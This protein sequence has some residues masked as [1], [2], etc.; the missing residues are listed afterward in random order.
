MS[1]QWLLHN[2]GIYSLQ[3]AIFAATGNLLAWLFRIHTPKVLLAWRQGLLAACLLLPLLQPWSAAPDTPS[4]ISIETVT[5]ARLA[6]AA[7]PHWVWSEI[8]I[9][10]VA[11]GVVVRLAWLTLG[12][13][14]LRRLRMEAQPFTMGARRTSILLSAD[15]ASPVTF[16]L[17]RPV[18]LL[19]AD[20]PALPASFRRAI[21][22]HEFA[23][24]RRLDWGCTMAEELLRAVFWFHPAIHWMLAGIQLVREQAVDAGVIAATGSRDA[25]LR[26]LLSVAGTGLQPDLV[27]APLFLRGS[28]LAARVALIVKEPFM[29]TKRLASSLATMACVLAVAA[30]FLIIQFPLV[31]PAQPIVARSG[32]KLIHRAPVEYPSSAIERGIAGTVIVEATLN[33]NG[34][35]EDAKVVSGPEALRRAALKSVLEWHYEDQRNGTVQVAIDF[36]LPN[37]TGAAAPPNKLRRLEFAGIPQPVQETVIARAGLHEGQTIQPE[38]EKAF[39]RTLHE[40]DEHLTVSSRAS[41]EGL[42]L[43]VA[44]SSPVAFAAGEGS[45]P[46]RIRVGGNLQSAN[47]LNKVNPVYPRA[48]KQ[49]RVQG[50]VRMQALIGKDGLMEDLQVVEGEPIL[51]E[52]AQDAVWK[53]TYRPT[54]LNGQPVEVVTMIDVNF[55]LTK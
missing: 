52:A 50:K 6:P 36:R 44:Y 14:R 31:A 17:R 2:L 18:I 8:V 38:D 9:A 5:V 11:L 1:A 46:Q 30:R 42:I 37:R 13:V 19:P 35:V 40:I 33:E 16:G 25:Y 26:A 15:V 27:P 54:L 29:S 7:S 48:A 28:H 53:W 12:L 45:P 3:L 23:H 51:A 24:V 49:D 4:G 10:V 43:R 47:I 32:G 34:V 21:L 39:E 41:S 55:T 20:F 22:C